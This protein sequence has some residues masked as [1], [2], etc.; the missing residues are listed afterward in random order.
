MSVGLKSL[1]LDKLIGSLGKGG[2]R[3]AEAVLKLLTQ[4]VRHY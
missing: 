2:A 4:Q 3:V 1:W